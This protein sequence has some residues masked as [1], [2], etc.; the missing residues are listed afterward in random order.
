MSSVQGISIEWICQYGRSVTQDIT[1]SRQTTEPVNFFHCRCQQHT[2]HTLFV[3]V[4]VMILDM[5][6]PGVAIFFLVMCIVQTDLTK[7]RKGAFS[8]VVRIMD[9]NIYKIGGNTSCKIASDYNLSCF[10][11]YSKC[12][13]AKLSQ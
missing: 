2:R 7:L 13:P 8:H 3:Y 10:P 9:L 11:H 6:F 5:V 4:H 12:Y 1:L